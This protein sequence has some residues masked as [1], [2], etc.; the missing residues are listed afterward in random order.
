MAPLCR[1]FGVSREAGYKILGRHNEVG[2][3]GLTTA[4][5]PGQPVADPDRDVDRPLQ[6]GQ[7]EPRRLSAVRLHNLFS[8]RH[9]SSDQSS[10]GQG[11]RPTGL[12]DLKSEPP[13]G[14][15]VASSR[16]TR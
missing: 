12:L 11:P 10:N 1:E 13:P 7:A 8:L 6:A 16:I 2:P 5:P 14:E 4:L 3:E 15:P 9:V